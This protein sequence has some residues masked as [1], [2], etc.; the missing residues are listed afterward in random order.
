VTAP[1]VVAAAVVTGLA[2]HAV[3]ARESVTAH[4]AAYGHVADA[5]QETP[6][7]TL[8]Y[9]NFP[10]PF[11]GVATATTCIWFDLHQSSS[12][13]LSVFDVRGNLVRRLIPS[14]SVDGAF[15]AGRYGRV[16][17]G[18]NPACDTRFAWDGR[19]DAGEF[20]PVGVYLIRLRTR[21]YSGVKKALF[22]G[23]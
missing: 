14:A 23:H 8:L 1:A 6:A 5:Q 3:A 20:V 9:Q 11:P 2:L 10:N 4:S 13:D 12:V 19:S 18:S 17:A 22:R 16:G 7:V 15:V 21:T